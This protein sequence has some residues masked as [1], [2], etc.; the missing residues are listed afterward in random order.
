MDYFCRVERIIQQNLFCRLY[1]NGMWR[2]LCTMAYWK[3]RKSKMAYWK[4]GRSLKWVWLFFPFGLLQVKIP[5]IDRLI[6]KGFSQRMGDWH[7][8]KCSLA[9]CRALGFWLQPFVLFLETWE[10]I[11]SYITRKVK[12]WLLLFVKTTFCLFHSF[13]R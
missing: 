8:L 11:H 13:I 3:K 4:E 1:S 9:V 2:M 10:T 5:C 7:I 12:V 6:P